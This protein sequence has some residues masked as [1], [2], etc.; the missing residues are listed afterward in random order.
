MSKTTL[1]I[2]ISLTIALITI[3]WFFKDIRKRSNWKKPKGL[4]PIKWKKIL[5][6]KVLF[7]NNLTD[8]EK[9]LFE[10]KIFEFLTN[11]RI[12]GIE[13]SVDD[14]DK[15]L[16]ASSAIIP[17]FKFPNWQY[18]NVYEVLLYPNQ[19]N[20]DFQTTGK[21]RPILGM[22]GTGYMEG[23]M[24]LSKQALHY[25][26]E[27]ESDKKNTA[28]HE[29]I[30]LIDKADGSIDGIPSLLLDKQ[31]TIPWLDLIKQ[32]IDE[33]SDGK[34]DINPYGATKKSEFFPVISEYFFERPKLLKQ[35][36][37]KLYKLLEKIFNQDMAKKLKK[38]KKNQKI[39]R[40]DPCPCGSGKKFKKCC[41]SIHY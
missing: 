36:H 1:V 34:S 10:F 11:C 3:I 37:P 35:K 17:I 27:N 31:Y 7:Y 13:T 41:G 40:N 19:F 2:I 38:R 29:F 4:F 8:N 25:G 33:I 30:H 16:V 22:V 39:G 12:T 5:I 6:E 14:V 9:K 18:L 21:G 20:E 26:F 28:I 23:K 32:N 15:V 24:I